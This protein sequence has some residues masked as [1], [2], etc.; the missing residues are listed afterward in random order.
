[1]SKQTCRSCGSSRL[2]LVIDLGLQPLANNLLAVTDLNKPEPKYPLAVQVCLDCWLMQITHIV[3]PTALF[4]EYIYFS[5]FSDAMLKHAREASQFYIQEKCLDKSSLVIEVASNDGYLLKNFVS[6][7]IPALG[8][9]PAQN[10]AEVARANGVETYCAFFGLESA[11]DIK[12]SRGNADLI[13]GNNVFAHAPDSNDFVAGLKTLLKPDGWIVLEFPYGVEMIDNV[14]FDTIYHEHV[15]YYTLAPLLPLL[16]RHGLEAFHV[17]N[18]QIHGGSL[19]IFIAH[20]NAEVVRD[21]LTQAVEVEE[22]KGVKTVDYYRRF[23]DRAQKVKTDLICFLN[24]QKLA[25]KRVASY[26]ASAK[27]STL[28]NYIGETANSVEFISDRSTYKQGKFSPG[29]HIPIVTAEELEEKAPDFALLLV[30]N[31]ADEVIK[32]Q[33]NYLSKGGKFVI[34]LPELRVIAHEDLML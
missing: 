25:R 30:W 4:S 12:R 31:F 20:Q 32:Q 21:S 23:S 18:L 1:M 2:E 34:P 24:E 33:I 5:S 8:F 29:H 16:S 6:A 26:G 28:L 13:L 19:R 9:E 27:G 15:F 14:E 22:L 7:G 3:P 17:E 10:V 11:T